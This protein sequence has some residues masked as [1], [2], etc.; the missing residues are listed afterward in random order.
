MGVFPYIL[1]YKDIFATQAKAFLR[2][3]ESNLF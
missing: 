2:V 1:E 3:V